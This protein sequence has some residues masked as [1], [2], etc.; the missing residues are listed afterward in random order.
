MKKGPWLYSDELFS[1]E[2]MLYRGK[3]I[4][5][6]LEE[7]DQI[8]IDRLKEELDTT[9]LRSQDKSVKL[10]LVS[11]KDMYIMGFKNSD[12]FAISQGLHREYS[13]VKYVDKR[14]AESATIKELYIMIFH[15][16][17][18]KAKPKR[19][20]ADEVGTRKEKR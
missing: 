13:H 8:A 7:R 11:K 18:E 2:G 19:K 16:H 15:Q 17:T 5:T 20:D 9:I 4:F 10:D 6:P 3:N 12:F 1:N 14:R